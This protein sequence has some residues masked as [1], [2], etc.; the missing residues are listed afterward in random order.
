[1]SKRKTGTAKTL[2]MLQ[3]LRAPQ[4][5]RIRQREPA[6]VQAS[7]PQATHVGAR[8]HGPGLPPTSILALQRT[9]GN[10][11]VQRMLT[12]HVNNANNE[13]KRG[14]IKES[15]QRETTDFGA[16]Q[17]EALPKEGKSSGKNELTARESIHRVQRTGMVQAQGTDPTPPQGQ[18]VGTGSASSGLQRV[19]DAIAANSLQALI[20]IQHELRRQM[21]TDPLNSPTEARVGLATARHWTM[22]RVAAI[23]DIY[24]PRIT[25]ASTG[26]STGTDATAAVKTLETS[27]DTEC[28][29][30]LNVL[31]EGDPQYRYE[32][33]DTTV[34]EKVF[35]A[36][37][38]HSARRGV[39][40][41]G[42][43]AAAEAESRAHANLP[44]GRLVWRVRVHTGRTG[45]WL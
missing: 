23:R 43:R 6:T 42:H 7:A 1:M 13:Q 32:H 14:A 8:V 17:Q 26:A 33:F 37:R 16:I 15:V 10:S 39:G 3:L 9:V 22:D 40:Q 29:P 25:A 18:S 11:R 19:Q 36:V 28:T 44:H 21:L 41:I 20:T 27:M 5:K 12:K 4:P 35:A 45:R 24:A 34:S 30:Y 2:E 31:M 38:L